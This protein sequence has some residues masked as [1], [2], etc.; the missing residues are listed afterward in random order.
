MDTT[1]RVGVDRRA[2]QSQRELGV[3]KAKATVTAKQR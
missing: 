1:M 3:A 2:Q